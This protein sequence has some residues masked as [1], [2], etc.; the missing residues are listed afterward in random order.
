MSVA[1]QNPDETE[2][3]CE[4]SVGGPAAHE[5]GPK[6]GC[7]EDAGGEQEREEGKKDPVGGRGGRGPGVLE[8]E[9]G[10]ERGRQQVD[11][12]VVLVREERG[13]AVGV[14]AVVSVAAAA[15]AG[16][17]GGEE[18]GR[19]GGGVGVALGGGVGRARRRRVPQL[20]HGSGPV[21]AAG[22]GA[23]EWEWESALAF[24]FPDEPA[25]SGVRDR[26]ERWR[27]RAGGRL[28][29]E[30]RGVDGKMGRERPAF[31]LGLIL[32]KTSGVLPDFLYQTLQAKQLY[33]S[34]YLDVLHKN[35]N[36]YTDIVHIIL[37]A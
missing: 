26:G 30:R 16:G 5:A 37:C 36:K 19:R 32:P 13:R 6:Q 31:C 29:V 17:G 18:W 27:T 23:R 3:H 2:W 9:E 25:R 7:A 21:A 4:D 1:S 14:L 15:A 28:S 20:R 35:K 22:R 24:L 8:G 34:N 11:A 33:F 10:A 12:L